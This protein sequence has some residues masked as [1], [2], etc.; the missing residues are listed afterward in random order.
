[1][2]SVVLGARLSMPRSAA[3]TFVPSVSMWTL[4]QFLALVVVYS[5]L[6]LGLWVLIWLSTSASLFRSWR[7]NGDTPRRLWGSTAFD[8]PCPHALTRLSPVEWAPWPMVLAKA[9][10][11]M[12]GL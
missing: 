1:M 9:G 7:S 8:S 4:P 11:P 10:A 12:R 5:P 2:V 3:F 6:C